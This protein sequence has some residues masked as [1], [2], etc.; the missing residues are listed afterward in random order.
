MQKKP[1]HQ[2]VIVLTTKYLLHSHAPDNSWFHFRKDMNSAMESFSISYIHDGTV[3]M[4]GDYGCLCWQRGLF[5][6]EIDY[7][8][9][10]NE[11]SI[12]YFREKVMKAEHDQ[13]ILTWKKSIAIQEI[14]DS[15]LEHENDEFDDDYKVALENILDAMDLF[16]DYGEYGQFQ[17]REAFNKAEC[18]ID[19]EDYY[20]YGVCYTDAFIMK[21]K[22]LC[23]VSEQILNVINKGK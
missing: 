16:E 23:S 3:C 22:M 12:G 20:N 15:I 11:T 10:N 9:P 17:M 18:R 8:F 6:D 4:T 21:F 1:H 14:K 5:P 7:G 13:K 2:E 19:P